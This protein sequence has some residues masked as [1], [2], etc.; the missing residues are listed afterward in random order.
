MKL[1][2]KQMQI[3]IEASTLGRKYQDKPTFDEITAF[4][5]MRD[6]P[7][8]FQDGSHLNG[9]CYYLKE[10]YKNLDKKD[11]QK[12]ISERVGQDLIEASIIFDE[13]DKKRLKD[14][15]IFRTGE[16]H[17]WK[18]AIKKALKLITDRT[19]IELNWGFYGHSVVYAHDENKI[20][21]KYSSAN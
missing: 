8:I 16:K 6:N 9:I 11:L 14:L 17:F 20:W 10:R 21:Y 18:L 12:I 3:V 2:E 4:D 5:F 1:T 7:D 13:N 15:F 19:V